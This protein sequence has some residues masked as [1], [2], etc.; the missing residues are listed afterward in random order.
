[1]SEF[2]LAVFIAAVFLLAGGI[3]GVLGLGLPRHGPSQHRN[4]AR[5]SRWHLGD[6]SARYEHVAGCI[7]TCAA[8]AFAPIRFDD[9]RH[10]DRNVF[11]R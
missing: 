8:F 9:R 1:M 11:H 4:D 3:K 2:S 7:G 5:P 6:P 10:C